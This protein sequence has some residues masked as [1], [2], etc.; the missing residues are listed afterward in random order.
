M[1]D[2]DDCD[3]FISTE[4]KHNGNWAS[5]DECSKIDVQ[6]FLAM[7]EKKQKECF[8][9]LARLTYEIAVRPNCERDW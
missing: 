4:C 3:D 6:D 9:R 1:S 8:M 5:C 2:L 7:K